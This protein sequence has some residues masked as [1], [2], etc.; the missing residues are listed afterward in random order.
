[1][2]SCDRACHLGPCAKCRVNIKISCHC[3][4]TPVY[5]KCGDFYKIAN[6]AGLTGLAWADEMERMQSCG[7]RCTRNVSERTR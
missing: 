5:H 7:S 2:H 1:M 4:T 6:A 3:G